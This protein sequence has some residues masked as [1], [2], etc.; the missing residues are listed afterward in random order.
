MES[1][2][3]RNKGRLETDTRQKQA[4]IFPFSVYEKADKAMQEGDETSLPLGLYFGSDCPKKHGVNGKTVRKKAGSVCIFCTNAS[5]FIKLTV[6][7]NCVTAEQ[8][9][10]RVRRKKAMEQKKE[11]SEIAGMFL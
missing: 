4:K 3:F 10:H 8:A 2:N 11:E 9:K 5:M 6:K 7:K 1:L